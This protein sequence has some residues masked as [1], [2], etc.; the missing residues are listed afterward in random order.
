[1]IG[2]ETDFIQSELYKNSLSVSKWNDRI[3]YYD[4]TNYIFEIE[5]EENA[6]FGSEIQE[7]DDVEEFE[8]DFE[9]D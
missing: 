2:K 6:C 7:T 5:Q 1:M 8:S 9:R 3:L 4:C